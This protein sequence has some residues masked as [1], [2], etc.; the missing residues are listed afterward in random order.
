MAN[1]IEDKSVKL[2]SRPLIPQYTAASCILQKHLH[3]ALT[4]KRNSTSEEMKKAA[5]ETR[6]LLNMGKSNCTN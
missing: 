6:Q 2:V 4:T 3:A 1:T 5:Q